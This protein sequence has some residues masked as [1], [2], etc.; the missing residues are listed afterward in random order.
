MSDFPD[1]CRAFAAAAAMPPS[2][3]AFDALGAATAPLWRAVDGSTRDAL[4]VGAGVLREVVASPD[5]HVAAAAGAAIAIGALVERGL[6][7]RPYAA[8]IAARCR[9]ALEAA[10]P[11]LIEAQA[12]GDA[13]DE[14]GLEGLDED[15]LEYVAGRDL[16]RDVVERIARSMPLAADAYFALDRLCLPTIACLTRDPEARA[17]ARAD[18]A[19]AEA[20]AVHRYDFGK[21]I[22]QLLVADADAEWIVLDHASRRGFV[23]RVEELSENW[24]IQPLLADVLVRGAGWGGGAEG[25]EDGLSGERPSRAL[26]E[27]LQ[28]RGP[29]SLQERVRGHWEVYTFGAIGPGGVLREGPL[30]H[31]VWNEGIPDDIP[32]VDGHRVIVLGTELVQRSWNACRAYGALGSRMEWVRELTR[33]EVEAWYARGQ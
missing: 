24:A 18:V 22:H 26:V 29:Q 25:P 33:E 20:A 23:V 28:G 12:A 19:F 30:E 9:E 15:A 17:L 6:S 3:E 13:L 7:P 21:W 8:T 14:T 10:A 2:R 1:R 16:P 5:V 31:K 4:E 32:K 11:F 27:C